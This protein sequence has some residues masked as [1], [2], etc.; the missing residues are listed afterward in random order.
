MTAW[1]QG[2]KSMAV[3]R[4]AEANW[5]ARPLFAPGSTFSLSEGQFQSLPA[6]E[7]NAKA[8]DAINQVGELKQLA[9][10]VAQAGNDAAVQ[11]NFDQA[12][13]YFNSLKQCG[14]AL[15]GPD[16]LI[17][18]SQVGKALKKMAAEESAKLG[19]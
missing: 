15:D 5:S 2:D 6:A 10:A 11:N 19:Q 1:R 16:S 12:R 13:K 8:N 7:R 3:S 17:L 18:V 14:E 9:R 4:F